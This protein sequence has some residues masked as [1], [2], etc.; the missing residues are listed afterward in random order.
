MP[1]EAHHS[2]RNAARLA[3]TRRSA[4]VEQKSQNGGICLRFIPQGDAEIEKT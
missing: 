2:L 4:A 3:A 1:R